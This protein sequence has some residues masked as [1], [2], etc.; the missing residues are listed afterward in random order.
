MNA[1]YKNTPLAG[2]WLRAVY[3][4]VLAVI[5]PLIYGFLLWQSR[6]NPEYRQRFAERGSWQTVP[7]RAAGG[8]IFHCVSVG[9]FLAARRLI[10]EFLHSYPTC[11]ITV[12]CTTPTASALIKEQLGEQVYHCYLPFD[13]P[14]AVRRFL[15]KLRPRALVIMETE[16]WPNLISQA[17]QRG[18]AC[19]LINARMSERSARGYHKVRALLRPVWAALRLIAVQDQ[20]SAERLVQ[21]GARDEAV[22]I[23][24]NLKYDVNIDDQVRQAVSDYKVLLA[25]RQVLTVASTHEGEESIALDA[26]EALLQNRPGTLLILVPRHQER[27]A[28]VYEDITRR[29]LNCVRRS[30][31]HPVTMQTQ[32]L[33]G[34]SMG[35]LMLWYGVATVATIGGSLIPRGGHNPLEAMVYGVPVVSGRH[36]FNFQQVYSELDARQAVR[37]VDD[38]EGLY[39]TWLNL[40]TEPATAQRI[41]AQAQQVFARHRGATQRMCAAIAH[42]I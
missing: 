1:W 36:V 35:E 33:L 8:V 13:T 22:H 24:G 16:L 7:T 14:L 37:W 25:S 19:C 15:N 39:T 28:A 41:G 11:P 4:I 17:D 27:F 38:T 5:L 12:T 2:G 34:D 21:I 6:R 29:G 9:E 40:L 31:G 20:A 18:T 30:S 23:S 10:G 26:F 32:V 3:S 42:Y